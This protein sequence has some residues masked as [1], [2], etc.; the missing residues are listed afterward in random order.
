MPDKKKGTKT[1]KSFSER[2]MS[3]LRLNPKGLLKDVE[4]RR[5]AQA[6]A[7]GFGNDDRGKKKK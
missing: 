3:K 2:L 5:R 1:K 4:K 7:L 6:E